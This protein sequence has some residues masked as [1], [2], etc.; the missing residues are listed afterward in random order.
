MV[1]FKDISKEPGEVFSKRYVLRNTQ[2]IELILIGILTILTLLELSPT[3]TFSR[4]NYAQAPHVFI[5]ALV[6]TIS[7][8]ANRD[9]IFIVFFVVVYAMTII[10]S[11][12]M[13]WKLVI[14]VSIHNLNT[15]S[16]VFAWIMVG[17]TIGLWI[18]SIINIFVSQ[19]LFAN[20]KEYFENL[21][22]QYHFTE[23]ENVQ[24][25]KRKRKNK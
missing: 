10:D 23:K 5:W 11:V 22:I 3:S 1:D 4:L 24:A 9:A 14:M 18:V 7:E 17:L 16:E 6:F 8:C 2:F 20:I 21:S 25:K 19:A 15:T 12:V 13:A